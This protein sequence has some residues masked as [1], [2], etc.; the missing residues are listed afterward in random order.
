MKETTFLVPKMDCPSEERLIRMAVEPLDDVS[1]LRF[2]LDARRVA[3]THCGDPAAI[4]DLLTPLGLGA[5]IEA[6]KAASREAEAPADPA[7]ERRVLKILLAINGVM[8]VAELGLGFLAQSTGLISDS[9][10]M[11][12]DAM[13]YGL[14]L[15]AVGRA[16]AD[17]KRA[18]RL[19][20][21]LQALLAAGAFAEVARRAVVGS[22]PVET[23]MIGVA[24]VALAANL[25]CVALLASHRKGGVHLRASWIFSTNDALANLGVI[26]A[27]I[28]VAL[29]GSAIPDLVIGT[30]V[31]VLVLTG[32]ARILR[33]R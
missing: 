23:L 28:L 31:A 30:L 4:L 20:G 12:A 13:V 25:T 8:F 6:T 33:L 17:Q 5:S 2:D 1:G 18:A 11:L 14:S 9:L 19:S 27:G 26:G 10:D 3:V 32:A 15:V 22:E 29:T 24:V 7:A 16:L 21:W